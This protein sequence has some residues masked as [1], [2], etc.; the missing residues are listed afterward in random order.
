M[1]RLVGAEPRCRRLGL[2]GSEGG[3]VKATAGDFRK[4]SEDYEG[5]FKGFE[6]GGERDF[7][8]NDRY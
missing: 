3:T 1:A 8:S 7:P 4:Y 6:G 5:E 2:G